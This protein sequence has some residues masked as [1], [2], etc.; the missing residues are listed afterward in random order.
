VGGLELGSLG[1]DGRGSLID[2]LLEGPWMCLPVVWC[3]WM[4]PHPSPSG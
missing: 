1:G 2:G 3:C 4:L